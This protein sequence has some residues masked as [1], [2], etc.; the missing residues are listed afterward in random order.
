MATLAL[1]QIRSGSTCR[2]LGI[3]LRF[4]LPVERDPWRARVLRDPV[5]RVLAGARKRQASPG[6]APGTDFRASRSL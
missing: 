6:T 2:Q 4:R 3:L 5:T 1:A